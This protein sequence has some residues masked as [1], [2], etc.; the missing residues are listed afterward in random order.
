ML[1]VL[2]VDDEKYIR[3]ELR[4]FLEKYDDVT[5]C[6]EADNGEEVLDLVDHIKPD[7]IFLDVQIKNM[8]GIILARKILDREDPPFIILATAYDEYAVQGFEI[9]VVD[10]ILKPF[11]ERRIKVT[12]DRIK[13]RITKVETNKESNEDVNLQKLCVYEGTHL[14]LVDINEIKYIESDKKDVFIYVESNKYHCNYSLKE[15]EER[16]LKRKFIRTH[17][18]YI[19]NVDYIYEIIPWFNYT[20]KVKM[21]N[22]DDLEIPVSRNYLKRFKNLL[23]I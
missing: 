3:D 12:L 21:K 17:K 23:G 4:Y 2:I 7:V 14:I 16:L 20:Y 11:S 15:L 1:S 22:Y 10:Y 5:I 13:S 18:S 8:N 9:N 19:V 6:G